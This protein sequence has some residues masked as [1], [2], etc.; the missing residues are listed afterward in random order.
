MCSL[1]FIL[2]RQISEQKDATARMHNVHP[3]SHPLS[4]PGWLELLPG[5]LECFFGW[6]GTDSWLAGGSFWPSGGFSWAA[7]VSSWLTGVSPG[8]LG[9]FFGWLESVSGWLESFSGWLEFLA[10]WLEFFFWLAVVSS[11]LLDS[12]HGWPEALCLAAAQSSPKHRTEP[13][14]SLGL[15]EPLSAFLGFLGH[16]SQPAGSPAILAFT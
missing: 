11:C 12:L 4:L 10:G 8:W 5:W 7:G 6:L 14:Q 13:S 15:S 1:A 2:E 16:A 3:G 9:S